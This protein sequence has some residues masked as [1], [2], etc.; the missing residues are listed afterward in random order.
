MSGAIAIYTRLLVAAHALYLF[1]QLAAPTG[2]FIDAGFTV[3]K[4]QRTL[5]A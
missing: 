3:S 2:S 5:G 1:F 4:E